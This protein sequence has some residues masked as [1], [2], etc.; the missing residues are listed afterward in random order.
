MNRRR[1]RQNRHVTIEDVARAAGVSRQTVSRAIRNRGEISEATR[2]RVLRVAE[3]LG[4]RPSSI[5]RGLA[6]QHTQTLGLVVLDIANPFFARIARGAGDVAYA[7]GYNLFLCNTDEDVSREEMA[8]RS[9]EEQRVDGIL[10]CSSRLSDETLQRVAARYYPLVLV[11]R[12]LNNERV[13][14]VVVDGVLSGKQATQHLLSLGHRII[15]FLAGPSTS[16][17]GQER[18]TGFRQALAAAEIPLDE[19]LVVETTP[20]AEGGYTAAKHLL[21]ARPD[22]TALIAYNDLVAVG[23]LQACADLGRRVPEGISIVGFDDV[24]LASLVTPPLTTVRIPKYQLGATAVQMLLSMM[25]GQPPLPQR[26][27]VETELIIRG[28]TGPCL[29]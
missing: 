5:A 20:D 22:I 6:T 13:G 12:T 24:P 17:S 26:I 28:T 18:L 14:M 16:R 7:H 19:K 4:Y 29:A 8:I 11:N 10:L 15:G 25:G 21:Q 27:V 1:S 3:E 9:L 2:E 23:T